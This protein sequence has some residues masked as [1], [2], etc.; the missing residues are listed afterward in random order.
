M[1]K[2]ETE[3]WGGRTGAKTPL[4][5]RREDRVRII[6]SPRLEPIKCRGGLLLCVSQF[7]TSSPWHLIFFYDAEVA[8]VPTHSIIINCV[9]RV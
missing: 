3:A 4:R 2:N 5:L 8:T 9:R 7:A 6:D 1:L